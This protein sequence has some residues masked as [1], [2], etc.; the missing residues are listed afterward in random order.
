MRRIKCGSGNDINLSD[1]FLQHPVAALRRSAGRIGRRRDVRLRR[2]RQRIDQRRAVGASR[3]IA[4]VKQDIGVRDQCAADGREVGGVLLQVGRSQRQ[5]AQIH[6]TCGAVRN[7]VDRVYAVAPVEDGRDLRQT[8]L[9]GVQHMHFR[10]R[11]CAV[12][13]RLVIRDVA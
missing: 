8:V 2:L 3:H 1:L 4:T 9:R 6:R 10:V 5:R 12:Q 11:R 7:D 13:Q